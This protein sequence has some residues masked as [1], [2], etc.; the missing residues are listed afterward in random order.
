MANVSAYRQGDFDPT[1]R[2]LIDI[3]EKATGHIWR[4]DFQ[5]SYIEEITNK[6]GS[7]KKFPLF[8]QMLKTSLQREDTSKI[9][10]DLLTQ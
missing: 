6:A 7:F 8:I 10:V 9:Y 3:E 5:Q 4:G 1:F 2:L